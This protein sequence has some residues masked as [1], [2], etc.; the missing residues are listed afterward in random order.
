MSVM[1]IGKNDFEREV[2]NSER[3]VLVDFFA[4]WCGPC[5]MLAPI[6]DEIADERSDVK[7]VKIN[8]DDEPELAAAYGDIHKNRH[9]CY[10]VRR[11]LSLAL[12]FGIGTAGILICFAEPLGILVYK[13]AEAAKYIRVFAPLVPVMYLDTT[14]DGMLKGLGQQLHSMFY[15]IIDA[16]LSVFLVWS[17]MP[18]IGIYGYVICVFVTEIINLAFSLTRLLTVTG[19][20]LPIP[21]A[22]LCPILCIAGAV[23]L[24]MIAMEL[25]SLP[26]GNAVFTVC[27]ILLSVVFY[28]TLLR[29][30]GGLSSEDSRWFRSIL[31]N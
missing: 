24:S 8:V 20:K 26:F 2:L 14:V 31:K 6:I 1:N 11:A 30:A 28:I 5:R 15:N 18:K 19:A 25:F 23:S 4:S 9:I 10:I 16:S 22:V 27:G 17:L 12:F 29:T 3:K 21:K 13:S 7:V